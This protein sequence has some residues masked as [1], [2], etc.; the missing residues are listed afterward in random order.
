MFL[1]TNDKR[2][3]KGANIMKINIVGKGVKVN[4][5]M[6]AMIEEKLSK[7]DRYF[8][9]DAKAEV[10]LSPFQDQLKLEITIHIDR[11]F[12]RAESVAQDVRS[13]LQ[14]AIDVLERQFRKNK[15]KIKKQ[16]K[17]FSYMKQY[18]AEEIPDEYEE[19]SSS[20][21][22]RHKAY[23]I[24]PMDEEEATLQMEMLGHDFFAFLN[25][26][27]GMVNMVYKR[28]GDNNYGWIE[29]EY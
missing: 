12:Y 23:P 3:L 5:N 25:V 24:L 6:Q 15:S 19:E 11:H 22:S 10:K 18:F 7:F 8:D 27:T 2:N 20:K 28:R 26:D 1:L 13:A 21:I 9:D 14:D 16:R 4:E 17:Q 29:L